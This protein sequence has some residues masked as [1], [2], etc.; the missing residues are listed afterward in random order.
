MSHEGAPAPVTAFMSVG[1]EPA[2]L[3]AFARVFDVVLPLVKPD[4]EVVVLAI[5]IRQ[6]LAG[7]LWRLCRA[8]W[9]TNAG[10]FSIQ[11]PGY[12]LIGVVAGGAIGLSAILFLLAVLYIYEP[13]AFGVVCAG[14]L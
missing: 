12:L 9:E 3:I 10:L 6:L 11:T 14:T 2:A 5:T 4:W 8:T 1:T 7:T 13:G